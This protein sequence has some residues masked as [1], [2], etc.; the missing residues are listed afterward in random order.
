MCK[1]VKRVILRLKGG[2]D[3]DRPMPTPPEP[4]PVPAEA[5]PAAVNPG[6][7]G[8]PLPPTLPSMAFGA[9]PPGGLGPRPRA[10]VSFGEATPGATAFA[11]RTPLFP[12]LHGA[13]ASAPPPEPSAVSLEAKVDR[14]VTLMKKR[15]DELEGSV[16]DAMTNIERSLP[17]MIKAAVTE[18]VS[19]GGKG[20]E[21]SG[22]PAREAPSEGYGARGASEG[23]GS[24]HARNVEA[25]DELI[26]RGVPR[27][28]GLG[29]RPPAERMES[30]RTPGP[31]LWSNRRGGMMAALDE[32][33]EEDSEGCL[34]LF[35]AAHDAGAGADPVLHF[36]V[37]APPALETARYDDP[38]LRVLTLMPSVLMEDLDEVVA[39]V[40]EQ[41]RQNY[42]QYEPITIAQPL[43]S[44][45]GGLM[46]TH[47]VRVHFDNTYA[48]DL[49]PLT[50]REVQAHDAGIRR[51][52]RHLGRHLRCV[53]PG[54]APRRRKSTRTRSSPSSACRPCRRC[55]GSGV[56][57]KGVIEAV[58]GT[59]MTIGI[60]A[61]SRRMKWSE[62]PTSDVAENM[63]KF[64]D[65]G[66]IQK[67]CGR[68]M[69]F[70]Y[71]K[72]KSRI[73]LLLQEVD[74]LQT[75]SS[76]VLS[77]LMEDSSYCSRL[78]SSR[79]AADD[80]DAM[81]EL[82]EQQC[83]L[84]SSLRPEDH[85]DPEVEKLTRG[86]LGRVLG[87][88]RAVYHDTNLAGLMAREARALVARCAQTP[89]DADMV[90]RLLYWD[91][92]WHAAVQMWGP[93]LID[94]AQEDLNELLPVVVGL[95]SPG[96]QAKALEYANSF[97]ADYLFHDST[98]EQPAS[99][100]AACQSGEGTHPIRAHTPSA[101]RHIGWT[102]GGSPHASNAVAH[103]GHR[104][105][106]VCIETTSPACVV[107]PH[108]R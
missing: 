86:A 66:N 90:E 13:S 37:C 84:P 80:V 107:V 10:P 35:T 52:P 43:R 26:A 51:V 2:G 28:R 47:V 22:V 55:M 106:S 91:G 45:Q 14:A 94:Q 71:T 98:A 61:A 72:H 95:M 65:D 83:P 103:W 5:A 97:V 62:D 78:F 73:P 39:T 34:L 32:V 87:A 8:T 82:I 88:I 54:R 58:E 81:I 59:T 21:P 92:E 38:F 100:R 48:T 12:S 16:R 40:C 46:L 77:R 15:T 85:I 33:E 1:L 17:V 18:A 6:G 23:L 76:A 89:G 101:A 53:W 11:A 93:A 49:A 9:T 3:G 69:T 27:G 42:T 24:A 104:R 57:R 74:P 41:L 19:G 70:M 44:R 64:Q 63:P 25:V 31:R 60:D 20:S 79:R 105:L 108:F 50:V 102:S 29:R 56:A 7:V 4:A 67:F 30:L 68:I 75:F 36:T 99:K 96:V